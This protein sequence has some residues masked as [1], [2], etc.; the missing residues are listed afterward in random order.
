[1]RALHTLAHVSISQPTSAC[2][3]ICQHTSVSIR[4][5]SSLVECTKKQVLLGEF[6]ERLVKTAA[7]AAGVGG[8]AAGNADVC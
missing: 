5:C 3:S 1:M 7:A 8:G 2:V 6:Y 4:R